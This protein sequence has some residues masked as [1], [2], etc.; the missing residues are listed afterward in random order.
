MCWLSAARMAMTAPRIR[1]AE[2]SPP[3]LRPRH[4]TTVFRISPMSSSRRRML[5]VERSSW[6]MACWPGCRSFKQTCGFIKRHLS[7]SSFDRAGNS[8]PI[9]FSGGRIR[10]FRR[11]RIAQKGTSTA[12]WQRVEVLNG[13]RNVGV[14]FK[15]VGLS[16]SRARSC[17]RCAPLPST[18]EHR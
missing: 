16:A 1:K 13:R 11:I 14:F 8:V 17:N 6:T 18:P 12:F 5:P 15:S 2:G 4:W 9:L 7:E 3:G 10:V